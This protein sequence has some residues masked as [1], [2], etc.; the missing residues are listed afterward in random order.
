MRELAVLKELKTGTLIEIK[1]KKYEVVKL[2]RKSIPFLGEPKGG[3]IYEIIE[4]K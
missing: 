3:Y 2:I 4:L 1:S